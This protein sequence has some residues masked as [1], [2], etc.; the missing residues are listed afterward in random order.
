MK[1]LNKIFLLFLIISITYQKKHKKKRNLNDVIDLK[2]HANKV[3]NEELTAALR[4]FR[5]KQIEIHSSFEKTFENMLDKVEKE[6]KKLLMK[7][8]INGGY[9]FSQQ[10]KQDKKNFN[11]I[12]ELSHEK[13]FDHDVEYNWTD[14]ESKIGLADPQKIDPQYNEINTTK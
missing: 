2:K 1:E 9:V 12:I 6:N 4:S 11:S 5:R 3:Y 14:L 13:D 10:I 8:L 7:T